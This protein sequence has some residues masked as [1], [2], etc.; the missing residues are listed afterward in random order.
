M[1]S[2][3]TKKPPLV[4][5]GRYGSNAHCVRRGDDHHHFVVADPAEKRAKK[6][7]K[8]PALMGYSTRNG[9]KS[10]REQEKGWIEQCLDLQRSQQP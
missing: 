2:E 7:N 5:F 4:L 9:S 6:I 8:K 3:G 1:E 10:A